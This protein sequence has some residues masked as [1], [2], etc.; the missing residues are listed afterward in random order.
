MKLR[1]RVRNRSITD[2][3][4]WLQRLSSPWIFDGARAA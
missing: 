3:S 4:G 1:S 2:P